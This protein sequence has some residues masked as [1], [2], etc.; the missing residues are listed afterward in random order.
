M[1]LYS[2]D[3]FTHCPFLSPVFLQN[4]RL[5]RHIHWEPHISRGPNMVMGLPVR[6]S[7]LVLAHFIRRLKPLLCQGTALLPYRAF[8][9]PYFDYCCFIWDVLNNELADKLQKLQNR[10]IRGIT[11]SD[12][13]SSASARRGKPGR[14]LCSRRKKQKLKFMFKPLN[15]Q[16]L[17][18]LKG[19]LK[20][21]STD[22]RTRD[23]E[24]LKTNWLCLS[25]VPVVWNVAS[26]TVG[27]IC[28]IAFHLTSEPLDLLLTLELV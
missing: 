26:A 21:F 5:N 28:G 18:Y 15:N 20:P 19:L 9:E 27:H 16:S 24:I 22:L 14:G 2:S 12:Y 11:K 7:P 3:H 17:E 8:I 6:L 25:L 10:A 4:V 23:L 13:Y 1:L